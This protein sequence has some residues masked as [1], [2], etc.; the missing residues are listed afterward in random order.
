MTPGIT[1]FLDRVFFSGIL[2]INNEYSILETECA[3]AFS[4]G[5][6]TNL[7]MVPYEIS[8]LNH[9]T[10]YLSSMAAVVLTYIRCA[11]SEF[12]ITPI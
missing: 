9:W 10:T 5:S 7:V 2:K 3:R 6:V 8:N 12:R 1:G 4:R 11:I